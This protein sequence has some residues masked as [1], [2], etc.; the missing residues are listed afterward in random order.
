MTLKNKKWLWCCAILLIAILLL[1]HPVKHLVWSARLGISM[2]KL[3]SG[4][5][6]QKPDVIETKIRRQYGD[7]NYEALCYRPSHTPAVSAVI[8]AAGLSEKGCYHPSLIALS[9]MLAANGMLVLTPDIREFREFKI[10]VEPIYQLVFWHRQIATLAEGEAVRKIGFA[11]ISFSGTL[12]LIAAAQPEIRDNVAFV[13]GIGPYSNLVR[14]TKEWFA[15][16]DAHEGNGSYPTRFYA[17]WLIMR[18]ALEML[19]SSGD[20]RFLDQ[21]LKNLIL[22]RKALP[23]DPALTSEGLRWYNLAIMHPGQTD[24]D[25]LTLIIQRLGTGIYPQLD[26][27]EAL[28]NLRC[29]LFLIHGAYDD[30][31]SPRESAELHQRYPRSHLMIN[32][33]LTHTHP[34]GKP[35]T[36]RQKLSIGVD[37]VGFCYQLAR[38]IQ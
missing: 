17:K 24:E 31:I 37:T 35:L 22:F 20:R 5:K 32:P 29:P 16:G 13:L 19:P 38:V 8:L 3:A 1:W 7:Q 34:T 6:T 11:G 4:T 10:A 21:V 27:Q 28:K 36:L 30:L 2:L 23:A 25:I 18:A 14:C 12:A 33:Y 15:A 9:R 26:P